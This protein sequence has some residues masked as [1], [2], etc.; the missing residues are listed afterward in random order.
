[1]V[2]T[3]ISG[4][5]YYCAGVIIKAQW[6]LTAAHC[7]FD[8]NGTEAD[9]VEVRGGHPSS[10]FLTVFPVNTFIIHEDYFK[11]EHNV[12]DFG[13]PV[14]VFVG[15]HYTLVG[16]ASYAEPGNCSDYDEYYILYTRV[17]YFLDWITNNTGGTDCL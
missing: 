16:I 7:F 12:G 9:I 11:S 1:M 15:A 4:S 10:Q 2:V 8:S 17:S 13:G 14:M 3:T 5:P 6:I